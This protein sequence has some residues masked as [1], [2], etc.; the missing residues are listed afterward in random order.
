MSTLLN[1]KWALDTIDD[2][3]LN[4][5]LRIKDLYFDKELDLMLVILNNRKILTRTI[6]N[7]KLLKNGSISA[8]NSYE[9]SKTGI[10]W[11]DLDEDLSLRGFL[12]EEM[13]ST[14]SGFKIAS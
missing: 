12:E 7:Y 9:L 11:S 14:V 5:G 4:K 8:L 3:I 10:H 13:L 2:M 1:N 6:S